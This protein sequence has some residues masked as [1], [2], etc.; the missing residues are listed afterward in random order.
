VIIRDV[1]L[2]AVGRW[3]EDLIF[4]LE[5]FGIFDRAQS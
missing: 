5:G 4:R 3:I 1:V 2:M